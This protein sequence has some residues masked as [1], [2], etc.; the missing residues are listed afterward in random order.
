M[1]YLF[2]ISYS[3][4]GALKHNGRRGSGHGIKEVDGSLNFPEGK[5]SK[6]GVSAGY[7]SHEVSIILE[8]IVSE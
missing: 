4:V 2:Y 3:G 5:P 7:G 8:N 6:K 1:L